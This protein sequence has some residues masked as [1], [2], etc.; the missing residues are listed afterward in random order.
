MTDDLQ[1]EAV[2]TTALTQ[3]ILL[4]CNGVNTEV[5]INALQMAMMIIIY[6]VNLGDL[7]EC[8]EDLDCFCEGMKKAIEYVGPIDFDGAIMAV[9]SYN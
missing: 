3:E 9:E 6:R 2:K 4:Q 8:H 1:M 5:I 7:A